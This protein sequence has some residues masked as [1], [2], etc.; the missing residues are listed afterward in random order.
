MGRV[1][2]AL[3]ALL[4]AASARAEPG[5]AACDPFKSRWSET[6]ATF[7]PG[8][9]ALAYEPVERGPDPMLRATN[10]RLVDARL[11]CAEGNLVALKVAQVAGAAGEDRARALLGYAVAA[12]V[13]LDRGLEPK[14]A[15]G[16]VETLRTEAGP[17][18][19][20]ISS[21][22]AYEISFSVRGG[23]GR[24]SFQIDLPEN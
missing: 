11:R 1:F 8:H 20:A 4:A 6:L 21:F 19:D 7:D 9:P 23:P 14:Q 2:L 15:L 12:L 10:A 17:Q 16:L 18:Q 5:I 24:D 13:A 3:A 22:G